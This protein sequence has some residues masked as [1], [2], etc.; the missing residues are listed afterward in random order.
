MK[1]SKSLAVALITLLTLTATGGRAYAQQPTKLESLT[2]INSLLGIKEINQAPYLLAQPIEIKV[3]EPKKEEAP[4]PEEYIVVEGDSLSKIA[5]A[6]EMTWQRLWNKNTQLTNQ[7]E[8]KVGDKII[9]PL[10]TDVLEDRAIITPV[11]AKSSPEAPRIAQTSYRGSSAGNTY[12]AGYC[13]AFVKDSLPWVSNG[14]GD[15]RSWAYNAQAQGHIVSSIPIVGAV[16]QTTAGGWG[17]VAVVIG[18]GN[19]TVTIR[20]MNYKGWNIVSER[21]ASTSSFN[22][23]Y[24]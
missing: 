19:G 9:I 4:K 15:A 13:T 10:V 23:I 7:D 24:P 11:V 16:A 3:E 20:E 2:N 17:H 1:H 14:W 5:K 22:Y 21:V 12:D 8:L 18:V 6:K